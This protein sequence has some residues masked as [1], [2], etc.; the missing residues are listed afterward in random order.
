MP[1]TRNPRDTPPPPVAKAKITR[2]VKQFS[3]DQPRPRTSLPNARSSLWDQLN[4]FGNIVDKFR[5]PVECFYETS[6]TNTQVVEE[7]S[8]TMG[9]GERTHALN[10]THLEM[11]R[12][13]SPNDP[14]LTC[15]VACIK[16]LCTDQKDVTKPDKKFA[17]PLKP[18]F[19]RN[20]HFSGR[21]GILEE[22]KR[23][24]WPNNQIEDNSRPLPRTHIAVLGAGGAGKTQ[25]LL[26]YM[27][28]YHAF[29]Q[30][31]SSIFW[32]NASSTAGLEATAYGIVE[33]IIDH[34]TKIWKGEKECIQRIA[35]LFNIFDSAITTKAGL[36]EAINKLSSVTILK[37]W[38][39]HAANGRW[40]LILDS[41]HPDVDITTIV[42]S[43]DI[44][45]VLTATAY[46]NIYPDAHPLTV[47]ESIGETESIDLLIRSSGKGLKISR[48]DMAWASAI[49]KAVGQLPLALDQVGAYIL[50]LEIPFQK[51]ARYL[52]N[53]PDTT[54]NNEKAMNTGRMHVIWN[55]TWNKLSE[56]AKGLLQLCALL[57]AQ[58]IP[59]KMLQGGKR[60]IGWMIDD[61]TIQE[62]ISSLISFSFITSS[63]DDTSIS[64]HQMIHAWVRQR[65]D[66][67]PAALQE[68]KE[69]VAYMVTSS[70]DF[71]DKQSSSA[72]TNSSHMNADCSYLRQI[73]PH[74]ERVAEIVESQNRTGAEFNDRS[75]EVVVTLAKAYE[76]LSEPM[77]AASLY[78]LALRDVKKGE[79]TM[80]DYI[81]MDAFGTNLVAHGQLDEAREWYTWA[82]EGA[83]ES[84]GGEN[85]LTITLLLHLA[86][87]Y[88][89]KEELTK[90]ADAYQRVL[91]V[92]EKKFGKKHVKTLKTRYE[93]AVVLLAQG[94]DSV[95]L[96]LLQTVL[97]AREKN[98][99]IGPNHASTL[100]VLQFMAHLLEKQGKLQE[101]LK[102]YQTLRTRRTTVYGPAHKTTLEATDAISRLFVASRSWQEGLEWSEKLLEG[103][104]TM[105]FSHTAHPW[106]FSTI[107]RIASLHLQLGAYDAAE[108][109]Y[110]EAYIGYSDINAPTELTDTAHNLALLLVD[111][112]SYSDA[113][114]LLISSDNS[115]LPTISASSLVHQSLGDLPRSLSSAERAVQLST[116]T[117]GAQHPTTLSATA[118]LAG[119]YSSLSNFPKA[120]SLFSPLLP[121]LSTLP[122]E[123]QQSYATH[124]LA[125]SR[126]P[127]ALEWQ[128]KILSSLTNSYNA[129][130]PKVL[131]S[132]YHLAAAYQGCG[133]YVD[134]SRTWNLLLSGLE[135]KHPVYLFATSGMAELHRLEGRF[136]QA[137]ALFSRAVDGLRS[138]LGSKHP[139]FIRALVG[140]AKTSL[141]LKKLEEA[142]SHAEEAVRVA[143]EVL[144]EQ[145]VITLEAVNTRA[146]VL[147]KRRRF[148]EAKKG[149]KEAREGREKVLGGDAREVLESR[150]GEKKSGRW[151]RFW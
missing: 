138:L 49:I 36:V 77:K 46:H 104:N 51:Y 20:V 93:L 8:A 80:Q 131:L 97:E 120:T 135:Q 100:E 73:L 19:S 81:T 74:I 119:L 24:F 86:A 28:R 83:E 133:R 92:Q 118:H 95:S 115:H 47:A 111:R 146:E 75:K 116:S 112:G 151:W 21:E 61:E 143:R 23:T 39:S 66:A 53:E 5:I 43:N 6:S 78:K 30:G 71:D 106:T 89:Q 34:Y 99:S 31:Y 109:K 150:R 55:I 29:R 62:T 67:D 129:D 38:L 140:L 145:G 69:Q 96:D 60:D 10:T 57:Q 144:G 105:L 37:D 12:F 103:I 11:C 94:N 64:V 32:L 76:R 110:R 79:C 125:T 87:L 122:L 139:E 45:H 85:P 40:L 98:P 3:V 52:K 113:L 82:L 123:A 16:R 134:A 54:S 137:H 124:L 48:N 59:L 132:S 56:K 130:H 84:V 126:A 1:P 41:I 121:S 13:E 114:S 91:T 4:S 26:E 18:P 35:Q 101:S 136:D 58:D 25:I 33:N 22:I 108:S 14:N 102:M 15:I 50:T 17:I 117:H 7:V 90:A 27:Y 9:K 147:R 107:S 42:P 44:G 141:G 88:T 70:F 128:Q 148:K 2:I 142:E 63:S 72:S 68:Y 65:L 149:F 127:E